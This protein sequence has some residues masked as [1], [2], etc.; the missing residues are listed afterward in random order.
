MS[1]G[2]RLICGFGLSSM[3]FFFN[4]L[5]FHRMACTL[6]ANL[7]TSRD[8]IPIISNPELEYTPVMDGF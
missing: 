6:F 4:C 1:I 2:P 7:L 8:K 5:F 3:S